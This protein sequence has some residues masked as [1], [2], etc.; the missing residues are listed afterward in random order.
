MVNTTLK[1]APKQD[2]LLRLESNFPLIYDKRSMNLPFGSILKTPH[3]FG[4]NPRDYTLLGNYSTTCI[5][6]LDY[7]ESAE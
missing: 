5:T 4:Q 7:G 2:Q 6:P 3:F 1:R